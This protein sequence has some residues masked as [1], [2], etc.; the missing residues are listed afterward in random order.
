LGIDAWHQLLGMS[1]VRV[2][3]KI[4]E[5]IQKTLLCACSLARLVHIQALA[6]DVPIKREGEKARSV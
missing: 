2:W 1:S 3:L 5:R 4:G 6:Q